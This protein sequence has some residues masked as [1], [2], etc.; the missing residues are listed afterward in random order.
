MTEQI[1]GNYASP[2]SCED[3]LSQASFI[4]S[5]LV[6]ERNRRDERIEVVETIVPPAENFQ[7]KIDLRRSEGLHSSLQFVLSFRAKSRNLLSVDGKI[8]P[9]WRETSL[10]MTKWRPE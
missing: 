10:D 6:V 1:A 7:R 3:P 9:L 4:D 5:D 8:I 2:R